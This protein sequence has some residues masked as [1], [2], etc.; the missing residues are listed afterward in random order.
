MYIYVNLAGSSSVN[1][2]SLSSASALLLLYCSA[3]LLFYC[4]HNTELPFAQQRHASRSVSSIVVYVA[5]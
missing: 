2:P 4:R 3:L 1:S 5:A